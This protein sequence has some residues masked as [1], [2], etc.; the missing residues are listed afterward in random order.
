MPRI[1]AVIVVRAAG[2]LGPAT[3]E[4]LAV[5]TALLILHAHRVVVTPRGAQTSIRRARV[6]VGA[7]RVD[8]ALNATLKRLA[9]ELR[10]AARGDAG[11][12]GTPRHARVAVIAV[13]RRAYL[14]Y[15]VI[16]LLT[17]SRPRPA[18]DAL[19]EMLSV[20][21]IEPGGEALK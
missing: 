9:T 8:Q 20:F 13:A 7:V 10:R 16:A 12:A 4:P 11:L 2:L 17:L 3:D 1:A 18:I 14:H 21:G 15:G 6:A 19:L 5:P